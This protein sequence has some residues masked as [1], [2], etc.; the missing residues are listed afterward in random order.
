MKILL[1]EDNYLILQSIQD[2]LEA[3]GHTVVAAY[4]G[5]AVLDYPEGAFDLLLTDW[6]MPYADGIFAIQANG[7]S[8]TATKV[9]LMSSASLS[10]RVSEYRM[11]LD[12]VVEALKEGG[13][14]HAFHPKANSPDALLALVAECD[15]ANTPA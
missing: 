6:Q 4:D 5:R 1:L 8:G 12:E 2:K 13:M 15:P 10:E 9:I 11:T 14:L 3:L 7:R